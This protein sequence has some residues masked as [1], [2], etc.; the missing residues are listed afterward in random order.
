MTENSTDVD[1]ETIS[2]TLKTA[3]ALAA[4]NCGGKPRMLGALD[5]SESWMHACIAR[6]KLPINAALKLQILTHGE[7]KLQQ[8]CPAEYT[9]IQA[10]SEYLK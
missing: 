6:A 10:V 1:K 7:F 4:E 3:F 9:E 8:L 2:E 5:I